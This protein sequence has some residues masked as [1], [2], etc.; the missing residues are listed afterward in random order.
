MCPTFYVVPLEALLH[1]LVQSQLFLFEEDLERETLENLKEEI[2]KC[3]LNAL[4]PL[5]AINLLDK[6]Q[7][8]LKKGKK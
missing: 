6:L 7:S 1:D 3:D 5:E 4:T 8:K 2:A